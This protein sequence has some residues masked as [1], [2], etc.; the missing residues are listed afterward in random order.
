MDFAPAGGNVLFLDGHV[1]W[2]PW[3]EVTPQRAGYFGW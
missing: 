2:R 1:E 3:P